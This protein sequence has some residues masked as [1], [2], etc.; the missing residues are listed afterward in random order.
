MPSYPIRFIAE[1]RHTVLN[2]ERHYNTL[3]A[4]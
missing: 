1:S 2:Y 4:I 3:K